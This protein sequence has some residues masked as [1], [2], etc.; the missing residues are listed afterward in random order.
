MTDLDLKSKSSDMKEILNFGNQKEAI[1]KLK[2]L[3]QLVCKNITHEYGLVLPLSKVHRIPGLRMALMNIQKQNIVDD[4][5]IILG[6]DRLTHDQSYKWVS[7][8]SVNSQVEKDSLLPCKFRSCF[9]QLTNWAV[10]T[11]KKNPNGKILSTKIDYRSIYQQ[12]HSNANTAIHTCTQLSDENLAISV[13]V[14]NGSDYPQLAK[15]SYL[16]NYGLA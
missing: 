12:C 8:T 10:M 6:K 5:G 9:K 2:L 15:M 14:I 13:W 7:G 1:E 11:R 16:S 4:H 3:K